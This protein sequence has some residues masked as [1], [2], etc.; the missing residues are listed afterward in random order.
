MVLQ[1]ADSTRVRSET[2]F[3]IRGV[4]PTGHLKTIDTW[5]DIA[6]FDQQYVWAAAGAPNAI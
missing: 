4:A 6:L 2:G 1:R 3:A 5:M